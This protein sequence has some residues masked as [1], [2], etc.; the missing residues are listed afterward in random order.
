MLPAR[1]YAYETDQFTNRGEPIADST[2]VLNDKVNTTIAEIVDEWDRGHD[3]MAFVNQIYRKIGGIHWVA[4]KLLA[5]AILLA[6]AAT[7]AA[8]DIT[9]INDDAVGVPFLPAIES[10]MAGAAVRGVWAEAR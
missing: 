2:D 9:I 10:A 3:E 8:F 1:A 5:A 7:S 4:T 6:T